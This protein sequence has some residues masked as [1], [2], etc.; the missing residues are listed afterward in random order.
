MNSGTLKTPIRYPLLLYPYS[1]PL[2]RRRVGD[3]LVSFSGAF[4]LG[5]NPRVPTTSPPAVIP[6]RAPPAHGLEAAIAN[7]ESRIPNA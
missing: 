7:S 2:R 4:C 6:C 3:V 5:Q 1:V